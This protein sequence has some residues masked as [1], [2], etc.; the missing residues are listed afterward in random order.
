MARHVT[1]QQRLFLHRFIR[2]PSLAEKE[3]SSDEKRT[4]R[5]LHAKGILNLTT[6][7][8]EPTW[9]ISVAGRWAMS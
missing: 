7:T 9:S 4:A 5:A 3:L 1:D 6:P 2:A 8:G